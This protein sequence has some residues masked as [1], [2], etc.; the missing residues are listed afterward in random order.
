M[1][2]LAESA[3][4]IKRRIC[5]VTLV[6][7]FFLSQKS[8][9]GST[10]CVFLF[11]QQFQLPLG[12][13][14][15]HLSPVSP[16]REQSGAHPHSQGRGPEG[17]EETA[18]DEDKRSSAIYEQVAK[19]VTGKGTMAYVDCQSRYSKKLCKNLIIQ[20]N[21]CNSSTVITEPSTRTMIVYSRGSPSGR[22]TTNT[23][24]NADSSPQ[25]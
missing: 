2:T 4:E 17:M 18:E 15:C 13:S 1:A 9:S 11:L 22:C 19:K 25:T 8:I 6:Q 7:L 10:N 21:P 14:P 5:N 23:S 16:E 24:E 20:P 12:L 3:Y